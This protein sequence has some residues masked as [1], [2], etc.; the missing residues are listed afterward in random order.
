MTHQDKSITEVAAILFLYFS[1]L[2]L[3]HKVAVP[4]LGL[5]V[6]LNKA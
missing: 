6:P 1:L 2:A 5:P 3:T 4:V